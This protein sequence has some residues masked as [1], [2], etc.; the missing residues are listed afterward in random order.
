VWSVPE[1]VVVATGSG[2]RAG[3]V[4]TVFVKICGITNAADA[5]A[6]VEAGADAIGLI[7]APSRRHVTVDEARAV[8][9]EIPDEVL[10]VGVF[11]GHLAREVIEIAGEVGLDAAQVHD[12][13]T[14]DASRAVHAQVPVLIRAL[15][16][17]DPDLATIEDHGADAVHLDAPVPGGCVP[18]DWS[19]VGDLTGRHRI[20][21]AGGLRPDTVAD[22]V[23]TV[24]PWGVDVASGV[25]AGPGRKDHDAVRRFVTEARRAF[26]AHPSAHPP[27]A[28]DRNLA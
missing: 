14:P 26:A 17:E 22:A 20:I 13:V 8:V 18:F 3:T 6:A 27:L 24:G 28:I 15:S 16:V 25:E 2:N 21:L 4:S 12:P 1:R 5:V 7:F 9:A 19:L 11:R 23:A 10:S